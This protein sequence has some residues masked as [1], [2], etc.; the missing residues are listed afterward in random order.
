M[1]THTTH[2]NNNLLEVG[3]YIDSHHGQYGPD[4]LDDLFTSLV[5]PLD[6]DESP[7]EWRRLAEAAQDAGNEQ[8]A[9]NA[10]E[11]FH[12]CADRLVDMLN[13]ATED[14]YLWAWVDGDFFLMDSVEVDLI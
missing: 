14:G 3:C 1:D 8:D 6:E 7:K 9:H 4:M 12:E 13:D 2:V 11:M 10:W 5:R